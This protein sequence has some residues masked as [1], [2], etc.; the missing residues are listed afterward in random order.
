VPAGLAIM[1]AG[2]YTQEISKRQTRDQHQDPCLV[3]LA[4]S[5]LSFFLSELE[6]RTTTTNESSK[7]AIHIPLNRI[8]H[9]IMEGILPTTPPAP[10]HFLR[11]PKGN[12]IRPFKAFFLLPVRLYLM[13][14]RDPPDYI[15][16]ST[17]AHPRH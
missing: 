13:I 1:P 7:Q 16:S 6:H 5:R 11:I 17:P 4:K 3:I 12:V 2:V 8:C 10:C 9:T 15:P 14:I